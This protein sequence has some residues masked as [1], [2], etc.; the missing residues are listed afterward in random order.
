MRTAIVCA[1]VAI[2]CTGSGSLELSLSLPDTAD[3]RPS[4]MTTITVLATSPEMDPVA[5]TS[6][7]TGGHTVAGDLPVGDNVQIDVLLRD[8]S[9]RLVGLGEAPQPID[10]QGSGET[11]LTIPVR[12]PF[13]YVTDNANVYTFDPSLDPRDSN[14]QGQLSGLN[15]PHIVVSVGGERLVVAGATQLQIVDTATHAVTGSPIAMPAMISDVA[16][17]PG[18][19]QVAVGHM[20]GISIVDLDTQQ[21]QTANVGAV[22]RVTVG[23]GADGKMVAYGL[24][25]RVLAPPTPLAPCTGTSSLVAVLVD[26]PAMTAPKPLP[27]AVSSIAAAPGAPGVFAAEPCVGQIGK[28]SGDPTAETATLTLDKFSDL[29]N[30]AAVAVLDERIWAAGT[31]PSTPVCDPPGTPCVTNTPY[32]CPE[33]SGARLAYVDQGARL[34]VQSIPLAGGAPVTLELPERR[35]TMIDKSDPAEQHAQVLHS[36]GIVPLDLVA[37][38]GGQYVS[39]VA[40][41]QYYIE[42]LTDQLT[43]EQILPCLQSTTGDWMLLD[44]ASS[45]VAQRVRTECDITVGPSSLFPQWKC[46]A[47]PEGEDSMVGTYM[48]TSIGALFGAR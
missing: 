22:D 37:Q 27:T 34:V 40:T 36:L 35:E 47:P 21:V 20:S 9:S 26:A 24:V 16:P 3:L 15:G 41:S 42:S 25:G 30:A 17:V 13:V 29:E 39:V 44:M 18:T 38:P 19:H 31:H 23:P 10:I 8:V 48:P 45:S 7:I 33:P 11:D 32:S 4:G 14:F 1:W 28:L 46:G 43:G 2:G 6:V 12:R 5:N